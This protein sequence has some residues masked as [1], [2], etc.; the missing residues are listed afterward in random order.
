MEF[1]EGISLSEFIQSKGKENVSNEI[2]LSIMRKVNSLLLKLHA[3]GLC[4]RDIKCDN[5]IIN[6]DE[7]EKK[8]VNLNLIDFGFSFIKDQKNLFN[9]MCGTPNYMAPEIF[10]SENPDL[11]KS[12]LWSLGIVFY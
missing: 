2:K 11:F 12:D 5:I 1:I 4:H 7:K 9:K 10:S 6:Y 8:I 3:S